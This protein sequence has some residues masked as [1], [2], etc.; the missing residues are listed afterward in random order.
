MPAAPASGQAVQWLQGGALLII[1]AVLAVF[2]VLSPI[3]LT[4]G[5]LGNVLQQAAVTGTLAFGL[6][7]VLTGGGSHSLTGGI[8][9]SVAAN[10]GLSAAVF[11][12]QL[13][14]GHSL[15]VALGL[16]Y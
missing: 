8:D 13:A 12:T 6:T 1:V 9:L 4:V 10:M 16:A 2:A 11:A 15:T 5:N 7:L 14:A 3:F